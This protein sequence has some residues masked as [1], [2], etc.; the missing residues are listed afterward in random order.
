MRPLSCALLASASCAALAVAAPAYAQ[1]AQEATDPCLAPVGQ[2]P[3]G[4]TC[5]PVDQNA[6]PANQ[7][8]SAAAAPGD[9]SIVVVGSR[10]R[11]QNLDT[12]DPVKVFTRDAIVDAGFTSTAE[13]L[14][15]VGVT[16]ATP[17]ITDQFGGLVVDG[18]PGV[19]TISLR[20][21][22]PERTLVLL[23]GRRLSP[24]GT[25][26]SVGAADLNV[27]PS[28]IVDRIE[29]LG[30][31]ASSVYGSDAIAGVV[32]IVTLKKFNGLALD[33]DVSVPET[34]DGIE[35][36][37]AVTAG[38]SGSRW[39]LLGSI[40][41]YK[42]SRVTMGD[43]PW[44]RC[45]QQLFLSGAGTKKGSGDFIDPATGKSK[46]FPLE[47]GGVTQNTIGTSFTGGI[48]AG[49]PALAPGFP[50]GYN[51]Y[52]NRFS[53]NSAVTTGP[54]P[55]FQCV[56]GFLYNPAN[57]GGGGLSSTNIRNT[58][59]SSLLDQDVIS[60]S[61]SYVGY[62]A[63]TYDTGLFGDGQLYGSLLVTRRKSEQNGNLQFI[64]DYPLNSPLIPSELLP[65]QGATGAGTGIRVFT[66]YGIYHNNQTEDYVKA[67]GGFRGHLPFLPSWDYDVYASKSWSDGTYSHDAILSDRLAKSFDVVPNGSGGFDCA[68]P[69][70]GCV[71][72]PVL[73]TGIIGGN[74]RTSAADWF[75]YVSS[76]D[77]GHTKFRETT[78]NTTFDGPLF[79]LQ[80]GDAQ[81]VLGGEYRKS[82]IDDVPSKDSQLGNVF[83]FTTA[84]I[85]KGSDWVWEGYGEVDLPIF[86]DLPFAHEL[87]LDGSVR[88]TNYHSYG[89]NW[90][91]K[92]GGRWAPTKWLSLRGSYG[93][94]Y[95][96]PALF[97][98]FLGATSGF[99]G[100][101]TDICDGLSVANTPPSIL[102]ACQA[103]GLPLGFQQNNGVTVITK[104]GA[105]SGLKAETSKNLTFGAVL[106][107]HLGNFGNF[108]FAADYYR[109][110]VNNGVSLLGT[111]TLLQ[112]CYGGTHPEY[113]QFISRTPYTGPGT[114]ALTVTTSYINVAKFLVKGIDFVMRYD[115]RLA[116]GTLDI[117]AEAVRTLHSVSQ[118]DPN[119]S[120]T[121][122]VGSIGT[123]KWAGTGD[124][125]YKH[126][127]WY[128]RWGVDFIGHTD[129]A[130]LT[131]PLG[132]SPDKYDFRVKDYWLHT[133]T[134]RWE[135]GPYSL[136]AG[137]R[138]VFNTAPPKISS[139]DPEV[140]TIANVPL[141][142]AWDFRGR[143]YFV[144]L[145]AKLT[146]TERPA[147][148]PPVV[149]PP[150]QPPTQTCPDGSVVAVSATC[151]VPPPAPLPPA[152]PPPPPTPERGQ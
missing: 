14:Q 49:S 128:F 129:D 130:F 40:E 88:W 72:A 113:C 146:G 45:P 87:D 10:I 61:K 98:Q 25:R 134:I 1:T 9:N 85:T 90:T 16:G 27:L 122:F 152:P 86:K 68:D 131:T 7:Q 50:A 26:G 125:G 73:T 97:E 70:G 42:R 48:P 37:Y 41:Y 127:S 114:G 136:T 23:N 56:S 149:V 93:T 30:T 15:S 99:L 6:A 63:G 142:S 111:G 151:P 117:G 69:T 57:P 59:P 107:P 147:P 112:G 31:G 76:V 36:R 17:Q 24:A 20:G 33:A 38:A 46:C 119:S 94:S 100:S 3:P 110:Q 19:N 52:C 5:P 83:N 102:A 103:Q 11:R 43:L 133:A 29:V 145:Q 13:A 143:T 141:Q 78:V 77:T 126:G 80:G 47:E 35:Q 67:D 120:A 55:G 22:G 71:A 32:N 150:V 144:N 89:S 116:G 106:Q 66:N 137:V 105:E 104:G 2:R 109:I 12:P 118:T 121:D 8:G 74:Y 60:P 91:Y 79:R 95:R 108:S 51:V 21:L 135:K 138:N 140:N 82:S 39:S 139:G 54:L 62:L 53:P 65:Y 96:A 124:I 44:A 115:H 92:A 84:P 18:G 148:P 75:N 123:P 132:F 101:T 34:G 4:V 58:F 64:L 28:A 81:M